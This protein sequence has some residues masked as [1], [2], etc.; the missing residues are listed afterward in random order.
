MNRNV[1]DRVTAADTG[2]MYRRGIKPGT[3]G[4]IRRIVSDLHLASRT[5]YRTEF[6]QDDFGSFIIVCCD[7]SDLLSAE[8]ITEREP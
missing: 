1:G 2:Y 5:L 3:E 8:P 7:D 6:S 4:V